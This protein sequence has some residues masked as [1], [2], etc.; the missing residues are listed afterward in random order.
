MFMRYMRLVF[1]IIIAGFV[2]VLY[3]SCGGSMGGSVKGSGEPKK[4]ESPREMGP[5]SKGDKA[6][7]GTIAGDDKKAVKKKNGGKGRHAVDLEKDMLDKGVR[8]DKVS[9]RKPG[10]ASGLK[11]GYADDNKQFNYFIDFLKKYHVPH[12]SMPVDERIILRVRDKA[13]KSIPNADVKVLYK[14][15]VL[16]SG[17][18]YADGSFFFF[19]S[20]HD[21]KMYSFKAVITAYQKTKTIKVDRQGRRDILVKWDTNRPVFKN[22]PL[23]ILFIFDT[24][25]SM[26]EEIERLKKT[27]EIIN[28]NLASIT[29]KPS[30][31]FG[32]VLYKDKGDEYV[33]R[34]IPFTD[35]LEAFQEELAKVSASGGGDYPEDL[36]SALQD[37]MTKMEWSRNGIR[38]SFIITDAP[39]HLDYGQTYSYAVAARDAK[40]KAIKI[41]S[42]GTGGLNINGEYVLRQISQ[43]TNAKYIF[44]TY[45]EKGESAGGREGSVS[46]HTGANFQTDK[47]ESIII[48]FAKEELRNVSNIKLDMGDE[49]FTAIRVEDEKKEET[50]KKLFEMAVRQ[51][52]DYSSIGIPAGTPAAVLPITSSDKK[53]AL[54]SEY[55]TEQ[56]I[57]SM[58]KGKTF[59]LVERKSIQKV[60]KE[61]ELGMSGLVDE[62]NAAKVGKFLGAKMLISGRLYKK[63][64]SYELF[65]KLIRVETAEVL[66]VTKAVIDV[67]LGISGGR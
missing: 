37:A 65:I 57:F 30:V 1:P 54:N 39:P 45:G 14:G 8:E 23:D 61:L 4:A 58:S 66:S 31:R 24:T 56:M 53:L 38:L 13:G 50:L 60:L 21:K 28:M 2:W 44:L 19:P 25:G 22:I 16:T 32:M 12:C 35:N 5:A 46:H 7:D 33:T 9:A 59:R 6:F 62:K 15:K 64:K 41:F 52:A 51:L 34:M 10:G 63:R 40:A 43:Y 18:T 20:E 36:Q 47:L 26:G 67:N 29:P 11:A 27:I 48:R 17:K 49:H 3:I 42:V 55:F